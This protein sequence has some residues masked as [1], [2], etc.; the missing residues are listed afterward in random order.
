MTLLSNSSANYCDNAFPVAPAPFAFDGSKV[1]GGLTLCNNDP[2]SHKARMELCSSGGS[3]VLVGFVMAERT[4]DDACPPGTRTCL[5]IPGDTFATVEQLIRAGADL[6]NTTIF[7]LPVPIAVV[8]MLVFEARALDLVYYSDPADKLNPFSNSSG[9]LLQEVNLSPDDSAVLFGPVCQRSGFSR[10]TLETL[11][12]A[13][14]KRRCTG[15]GVGPG[16]SVRKGCTAAGTYMFMQATSN[17][18]RTIEL[19]A[20]QVYVPSVQPS[21]D[22]TF[23]GAVS[24]C[25]PTQHHRQ[26][27]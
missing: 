6:T 18:T 26:R 3:E 19:R 20:D 13:I 22:I 25:A 10:S 17:A 21:A 7:F 1:S 8:E 15:P 14:E 9:K 24:F 2:L 5:L 4:I 11:H 12:S 16:G 27:F 23:T